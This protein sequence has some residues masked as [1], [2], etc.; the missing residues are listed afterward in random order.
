MQ[1]VL[2]FHTLGTDKAY[3]VKRCIIFQATKH[4][5]SEG[6]S[7]SLNDLHFNTKEHK[8]YTH[9]QDSAAERFADA[10]EVSDLLYSETTL[11]VNVFHKHNY[12]CS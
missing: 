10:G 6:W 8:E 11:Q 3:P 12:N 1:M 7:A 4:F 5:H 2:H 9:S